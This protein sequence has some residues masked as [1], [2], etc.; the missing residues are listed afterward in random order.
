MYAGGR[1]IV[2]MYGT[3]EGKDHDKKYT[4]LWA[5]NSQG[6]QAAVVLSLFSL[7]GCNLAGVR[8]A[9][10]MAAGRPGGHLAC[11]AALQ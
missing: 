8:D 1:F 9:V 2:A 10:Y 3:Q 7:R 5:M 6:A 4:V 11:G